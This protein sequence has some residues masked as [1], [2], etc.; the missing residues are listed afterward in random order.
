MT[1]NKP[2]GEAVLDVPSKHVYRSLI[3]NKKNLD[4]EISAIE[5]KLLSLVKLDQ[6]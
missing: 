5:V 4:T 2:H 3:R 6:Q 1:K